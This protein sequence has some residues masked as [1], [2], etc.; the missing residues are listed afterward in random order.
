MNKGYRIM[1]ICVTAFSWLVPIISLIIL[2][3]MWNALPEPLGVHF[4]SSGQFDV[5]S[6][7]WYSLYPYIISFGTL[8]L[9]S[10]FAFL[11]KKI[12]VSKKM[13]EHNQNNC[14]IVVCS[15]LLAHMAGYSIFYGAY[16]PYCVMSQRPL[17]TLVPKIAV[18][19]LFLCFIAM[20]VLLIVIFQ[21]DK[22]LR[23]Q[24]ELLAR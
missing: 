22:K 13:T 15:F 18:I 12:R 3:I 10:F 9:F 23:K 19:A 6:S 21:K 20:V 2:A 7:K 8:I 5:I 17:N 4:D 16:W 14:K 11:V 24:R 1:F